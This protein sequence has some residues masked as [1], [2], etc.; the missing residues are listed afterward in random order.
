M[1]DQLAEGR[2]G[3]MALKIHRSGHDDAAALRDP[4]RGHVRIRHDPN[5]E[6]NIDALIDEIQVPV[7]EDKLNIELMVFG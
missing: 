4:A 7:V 2:G 1:A 6:R 5:S 3:S